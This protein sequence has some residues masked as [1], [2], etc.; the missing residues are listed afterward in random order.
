MHDEVFRFMV[1]GR[2]HRLACSVREQ[3]LHRSVQWFRGGLVVK[4]HRL[5]ISPNSMLES[6]EYEDKELAWSGGMAQPDVAGRGGY[7]PTT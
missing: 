4:A 2:G 3:P 7:S 5:Y 1:K 6:N